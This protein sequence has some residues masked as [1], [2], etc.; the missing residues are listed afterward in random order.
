MYLVNERV[1]LIVFNMYIVNEQIR[2]I[3]FN[4][5]LVNEQVRLIVFY[6]YLVNERVRLIYYLPCKWA[7]RAH[8]IYRHC[9]TSVQSRR[10]CLLWTRTDSAASLTESSA[11]RSVSWSLHNS[12]DSP[13]LNKTTH[14][15][16][17]RIRK[18][19]IDDH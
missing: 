7:S 13:T 12:Q 16:Y 9:Q 15:I 2:L 8:Y 18:L 5:Y 17:N 11:C 6:T 10:S 3:V 1:I 4:I 19:P 14:R